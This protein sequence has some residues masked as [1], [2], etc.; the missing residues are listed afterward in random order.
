MKKSMKQLKRSNE[1]SKALHC[2]ISTKLL[3]PFAG[4]PCFRIGL[5]VCQE[6][7]LQSRTRLLA[8]HSEHPCVPN[9]CTRVT[10]TCALTRC[11]SSAMRVKVGWTIMVKKPTC[12]VLKRTKTFAPKSNVR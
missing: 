12:R 2:V 11:C 5:K 3:L 4:L 10:H 7:I 8:K 1:S 6:H 9:E